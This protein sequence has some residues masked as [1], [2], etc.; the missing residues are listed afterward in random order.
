MTWQIS[1]RARRP[2]RPA[3]HHAR[4]PLLLQGGLADKLDNKPASPAPRARGGERGGGAAE[5]EE[6]ESG[7]AAAAEPIYQVG[8][9]VY[10]P[11]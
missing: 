7:S 3:S 10:G 5:E 4:P 2:R 6:A 1:E 9:I 11:N 8:G